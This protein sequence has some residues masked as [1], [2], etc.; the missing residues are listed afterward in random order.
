VIRY[1]E[2]NPVRAKMVDSAKDWPWSSH[3]ERIGT[4]GTAGTGSE[5]AVLASS[6]EGACPS[7][8]MR[9]LASLP[10]SL[11]QPWT[12]YVDTPATAAE[13]AKVKKKLK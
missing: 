2:A 4:A 9:M 1:V 7:T 12:D 6:I 8:R 5:E 10:I 11:P 3:R 13:L